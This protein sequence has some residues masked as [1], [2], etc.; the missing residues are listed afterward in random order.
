MKNGIDYYNI[1]KEKDNREEDITT[2]CR[3]SLLAEAT[4]PTHREVESLDSSPREEGEPLDSGA[5][6]EPLGPHN[7]KRALFTL[8]NN[9]NG[10]RNLAVRLN[11]TD[12]T[13]AEFVAAV[14]QKS[15]LTNYLKH[16]GIY[17][18]TAREWFTGI[19]K[20]CKQEMGVMPQT[21]K[22][23]LNQK[24]RGTGL[25]TI[26]VEPQCYG[27]VAYDK[28]STEYMLFVKMYDL[29]IMNELMTS[30]SLTE[31]QRAQGVRGQFLWINPRFDDR[32]RPKTFAQLRKEGH[33]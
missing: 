5:E 1:E 22:W 14:Q 32:Q 33:R 13:N 10:R 30:E 27:S 25:Q 28:E 16:T 23:H 11:L 17:K 19:R 7:V 12:G 20:Y 18:E 15:N 29:M 24:K 9:D 4:P 21:G 8:F 3:S 2:S 26:Q 31:K 6:E